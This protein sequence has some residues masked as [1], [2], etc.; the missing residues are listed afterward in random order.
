MKGWKGDVG[1]CR[2]RFSSKRKELS[3]S[4]EGTAELKSNM[5]SIGETGSRSCEKRKRD[6]RLQEV[7]EPLVPAHVPSCTGL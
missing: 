1:R 2:R 4:L 6:L 7:A 5:Y 3:Q